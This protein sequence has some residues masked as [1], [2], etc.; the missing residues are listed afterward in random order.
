MTKPDIVSEA[1]PKPGRLFSDRQNSQA[2]LRAVLSNE[3]G[4][5]ILISVFGF[6]FWMLSAGFSSRFNLFGLGRNLS[7]DAVVGFSM[8]VVIVTGGLNLAVGAIGVSAAMF[9]GWLIEGLGIPLSLAL[10]MAVMA[11]ATLGLINGLLVVGTGVHSFVVT[12]ATMSIF[13]GIMIFFSQ[14]EAFRNLPPEVREFRRIK[15]A[16]GY[17]SPL[18]VIAVV[19]AIALHVLFKFTSLGR[20][21][22][23]A[24]AAPGAAGLSGVRVNKMIVFAHAMSGALAGIAALML[25]SRHGAVIPSMAG[26]LGQDWL[27]PAFLAPVL[28]GTLLTGGKVSVLGTFLGAALVAILRNGLQLMDIGEF[29]LLALLGGLLLAAVI[30]DKARQIFLARRNMV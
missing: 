27:L 4:L 26:H 24:G 16:Y 23:A 1:R 29:W 6:L 5:I 15:L 7:I 18:F 8:M 14:A 13:F 11:G 2:V 20:E 28:G 17:I 21:I 10:P 25:A 19:V 22:L 30:L 3:F 12:L 9:G